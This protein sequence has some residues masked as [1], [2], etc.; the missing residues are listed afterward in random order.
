MNVLLHIA[1]FGV[2]EPSNWYGAWY[3]V[4]DLLVS[5]PERLAVLESVYCLGSY[6]VNR[7]YGT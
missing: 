1:V 4:I 6:S 5:L 7:S 2:L 3:N